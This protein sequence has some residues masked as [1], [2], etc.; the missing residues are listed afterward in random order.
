MKGWNY[1]FSGVSDGFY[2]VAALH[3]DGKKI[4]SSGVLCR[5][6]DHEI[7]CITNSRILTIGDIL[8]IDIKYMSSVL[9]RCGG[10]FSCMAGRLPVSYTEYDSPAFFARTP[11]L[12]NTEVDSVGLFSVCQIDR[13]LLKQYY[14]WRFNRDIFERIFRPDGANRMG[15]R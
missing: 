11:D 9:I 3:I 10:V 2:S 7:V 5:G 8:D 12:T 13:R 14:S 1:D 6:V 4:A 15:S